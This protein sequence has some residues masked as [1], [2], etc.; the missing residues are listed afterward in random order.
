MSSPHNNA[1]KLEVFVGLYMPA[2]M[3]AAMDK[4]AAEAKVSCARK[5][6]RSAIIR[7]ALTE[8]LQGAADT[9]TLPGAR[10]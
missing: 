3:A 6:T 5:I 1:Q 7:A 2:A 8:Y 10:Q 9:S 4:F